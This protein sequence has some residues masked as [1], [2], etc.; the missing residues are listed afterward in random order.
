MASNVVLYSTQGCPLCER[1][2]T[3][4]SEKKQ[5][6]EERNTTTNPKYLDELSAK[7]I[8]VVPT[9]IV[10][11]KAVPGFRPNALLELL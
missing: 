10:D 11:G 5:R 8:M 1:Y 9:V 2:R 3:L 7:G 6:F 4:L